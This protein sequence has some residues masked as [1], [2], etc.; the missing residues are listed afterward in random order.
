MPATA[1]CAGRTAA[2]AS[3]LATIAASAAPATRERRLRV[4]GG[5]DTVLAG[6]RTAVNSLDQR[7]RARRVAATRSALSTKTSAKSLPAGVDRRFRAGGAIRATHP[8]IRMEPKAFRGLS[9]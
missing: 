8:G 1:A 3:V 7:G 5:T 9:T 6:A 2:G 4:V